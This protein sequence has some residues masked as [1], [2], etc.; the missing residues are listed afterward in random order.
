MET[1]ENEL[2]VCGVCGAVVGA[3]KHLLFV[4]NRLGAKRYA[5]PTLMAVTDDELG[6]TVRGD[7]RDKDKP[8]T[9]EDLMEVTC[10][11]CRRAL[12]L[13]ELWGE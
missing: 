8:L 13:Q 1:I 11:K 6:L 3:R 5:N 4:A 9:R 10:P 12:V 7:G 2:V